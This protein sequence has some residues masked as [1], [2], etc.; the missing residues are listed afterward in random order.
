V[1]GSTDKP[2]ETTD[3]G[4]YIVVNGRRWRATDPGIPQALHAELVHELMD[5]RRE[6]GA[7][8]RASDDV[9][10]QRARDRVQDAKVALGERGAPWWETPTQEQLA[11]RLAATMRVL[12]SHRSEESTICPSDAARAAGGAG[13]REHMHLARQ[14]AFELQAQGVVEVRSAGERVQRLEEATGPLRLARGA[15][16]SP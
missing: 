14:V 5:A 10:V 9:R 4:R 16:W 11:E 15:S 6:V 3:D 8:G 1:A 7:A 12:L 2:V 13:W